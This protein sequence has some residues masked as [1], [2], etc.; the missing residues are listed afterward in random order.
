MPTERGP[1]S[2][3]ACFIWPAEIWYTSS[4]VSTLLCQ[5]EHLWEQVASLQ[6]PPVRYVQIGCS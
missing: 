4:I 3:S 2:T 6:L 5:S 1:L